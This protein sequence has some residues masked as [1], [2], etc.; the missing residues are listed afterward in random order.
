[1]KTTGA[2]GQ[3]A[4]VL[5]DLS[6]IWQLHELLMRR[7]MWTWREEMHRDAATWPDDAFSQRTTEATG[8]PHSRRATTGGPSA[9]EATGEPYSASAT[10]RS[11]RNRSFLAAPPPR[12]SVFKVDV[13]PFYRV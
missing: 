12:M 4:T 1:V 8:E 5:L 2:D 11:A 3:S 7:S 9:T 13:T 6:G 10:A